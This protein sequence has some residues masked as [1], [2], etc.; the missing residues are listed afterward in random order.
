MNDNM[1]PC[2]KL[3]KNMIAQYIGYCRLPSVEM[4]RA[5][6]QDHAFQV[7]RSPKHRDLEEQD[8]ITI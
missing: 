8:Q 2:V 7:I 4:F 6:L 3:P 5:D 1:K